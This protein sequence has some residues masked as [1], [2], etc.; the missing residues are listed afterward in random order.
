M[1]TEASMTDAAIGRFYTKAAIGDVLVESIRSR[2]KRVID[3]GSGGG[4]LAS[5]ALRKWQPS[6][7]ITVDIDR[8]ARTKLSP[9]LCGRRHVHVVADVLDFDLPQ[10]LPS[11]ALF[12]A[13]ICNPPY[14]MPTWKPGFQ[15]I[16]EAAGLA[17]ALH[18]SPLLG[19]DVLFLAQNLRLT[20]AGGSIGLIVPDGIVT[21]RRLVGL[22]QEIMS[23]HSIES[24]IQ[25]PRGCF[26]STDAQAFIMVLAKSRQQRA[27]IALHRL[28]CAGVLSE[29]VI[30]DPDRATE[31]CDYAYH[32]APRPP[33]KGTFTLKD[34]GAQIVRGSMHSG[35][36]KRSG[37]LYLHT[38][39]LPYAGPRRLRLGT[40]Q[41]GLPG[42][43]LTMAAAGDILVARI[44][45]KL[46]LQVAL[47][48]A[49][50][51]PITDC[52]FRVRVPKAWRARVFRAMTS[53]RG[54]AV[55]DAAA[56]GVGARLVTK[57]DLLRM[58]L[59]SS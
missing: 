18:G 45:R 39:D 9:E 56:R 26:K 15:A 24:V 6:E 8:K 22:R 52:I 7:I 36:A 20:K 58:E 47:V 17:A 40:V 37:R 53:R 43:R 16:L 38:T 42:G 3:L 1:T 34:A 57:D 11:T 32:A 50:K 13:A 49:G 23:A 30:V 2:P 21:G 19:A 10:L 28:D 27:T 5:A 41:P 12:D 25:L 51:I 46:H 35:E 29:P 55:L 31:R 59:P 4:S 48:T 14:I 54:A 44:G 33:A